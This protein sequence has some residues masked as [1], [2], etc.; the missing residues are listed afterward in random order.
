MIKI[1]DESILFSLRFL[2]QNSLWKFST[3]RRYKGIYSSVYKECKKSVFFQTE[4]SGD[5]TLQLERVASMSRE[6]TAWP[7]WNFCPIVL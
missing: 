1:V 4:H 2:S 5:L 6:L 3:F 7:D